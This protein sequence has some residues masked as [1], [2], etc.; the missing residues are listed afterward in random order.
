MNQ[1]L[2]AA[3]EGVRLGWLMGLMTVFFLAWF[4]GWTVWAF[5]PRNKAMMDE[6]ARMPLSDGGD[7]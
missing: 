3:A 6:V 2:Q 1:I 4:I 5:A 7:A